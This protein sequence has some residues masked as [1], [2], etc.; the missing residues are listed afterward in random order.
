MFRH[1]FWSYYFRSFIFI[2]ISII[3]II[4][5]AYIWW[6]EGFVPPYT[7]MVAV[8]TPTPLWR[9]TPLARLMPS[10]T[11][12]S[13]SRTLCS[14]HVARTTKAWPHFMHCRLSITTM[15]HCNPLFACRW[16]CITILHANLPSKFTLRGGQMTPTNTR[17]PQAAKGRNLTYSHLTLLSW[18][19]NSFDFY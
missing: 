3:L 10:Y 2:F 11:P 5:F 6:F 14:W 4:I 17:G 7:S 16:R 18:V 13:R 19:T 12:G 9:V 1:S 15:H 8:P